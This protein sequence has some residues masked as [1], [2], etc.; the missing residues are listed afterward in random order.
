[1]SGLA[2][3][4]TTNPMF[5]FVIV[6]F[7]L[8]IIMDIDAMASFEDAIYAALTT[9]FSFLPVVAILGALAYLKK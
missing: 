2:S 1:M 7:A 6:G 3:K 9:S 8:A 5:I 4:I